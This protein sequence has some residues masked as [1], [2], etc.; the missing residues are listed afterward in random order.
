MAQLFNEKG[1][2]VE[3]YTEEEVQKKIEEET[4]K[5]IEDT[6]AE[7]QAEID[8]AYAKIETAE[9]AKKD[10]EEK[11]S[12]MGDKD[13]NFK[14]LRQK[15]DEKDTIIIGLKDTVQKLEESMNQK[16]TQIDTEGKKQKIS[17]LISQVAGGNQ[18]LSKKIEIYYSRFN[19]VPK[20]DDE[21]KQLVNDA[22]LLA[23]GGEKKHMFSADVLSSAGGT[24]IKP[25]L[26]SEKLSEKGL[27]A[28]KALGISEQRLKKHKLI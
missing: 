10:L 6:N 17:G 18:E 3:A 14:N 13:T 8:E 28:A 27:E 19:V 25:D 12:K 11:I 9:M 20:T 1:D 21:L 2:L 26:T 24:P 22:Y 16:F 4:V 5:I 7:R 15:V 23:T